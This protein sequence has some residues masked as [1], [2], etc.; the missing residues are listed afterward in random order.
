VIA[1]LEEP[2]SIEL[3]SAS[4]Q[5]EGVL[6]TPQPLSQI[7]NLLDDVMKKRLGKARA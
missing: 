4:Q 2:A 1:V 6:K 3:A 5:F 7:L